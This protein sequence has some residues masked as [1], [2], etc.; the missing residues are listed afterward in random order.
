ML[1]DNLLPSLLTPLR[2]QIDEAYAADERLT[3]DD[4][5]QALTAYHGYFDDQITGN[6]SKTISVSQQADRLLDR[7]EVTLT[8]WEETAEG[9]DEVNTTPLYR[10]AFDHLL[11]GERWSTEAP[12]PPGEPEPVVE[13]EQEPEV[14]SEA[15]GEPAPQTEEAA[16]PAAATEEEVNILFVYQLHVSLH[17]T[18]PT[19]WRR[20]EVDAETEVALLHRILQLTFD[21]DDSHEHAFNVGPI[22]PRLV[23]D[24]EASGRGN[25]KSYEGMTVE[26]LFLQAGRK[27]LYQYGGYWTHDI[28][29][30]GVTAGKDKVDYPRCTEGE[31]ALPT[32]DQ[33]ALWGIEGFAVPP[34]TPDGEIV[35][36]RPASPAEEQVA[37]AFD[38]EQVNRRYRSRL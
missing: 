8:E 19:I 14:T 5:R 35:H 16:A 38:P 34:V 31:H 7:F 37:E 12:T 30:E 4:V 23:P 32:V 2:R 18:S 27:V 6:R 28:L 36:S 1:A 24:S 3:D 33:A 22:S 21:W 17:G 15:E 10:D 11:I 29:H 25:T 13:P 9:D 20:L 26:D